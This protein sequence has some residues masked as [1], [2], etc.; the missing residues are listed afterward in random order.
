MVQVNNEA[1]E[2]EK[3]EKKKEN[4]EKRK[5]KS[6]KDKEA[7]AEKRINIIR[8]I[9]LDNGPLKKS[10]LVKEMVAKGENRT[11]AYKFLSAQLA[12]TEAPIFEMNGMISIKPVAVQTELFI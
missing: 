6:V 12:D 2:R 7:N 11:D 9:L 8:T 3:Q 4:A 5:E 10:E 1:K